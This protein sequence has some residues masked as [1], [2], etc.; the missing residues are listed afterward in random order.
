P[1]IHPSIQFLLLIW[2]WVAEAAGEAG[3][4]RRPSPQ[5]RFPALPEGSRGVPRP[6]DIYN[7][8][9]E[10]VRQRNLTVLWFSHETS[11]H[12]ELFQMIL[13]FGFAKNT[14]STYYFQSFINIH[15][16]VT[17]SAFLQFY[18]GEAVTANSSSPLFMLTSLERL[19]HHQNQNLLTPVAERPFLLQ[20]HCLACQC[21]AREPEMMFFIHIRPCGLVCSPCCTAA[22]IHNRIVHS[23]AR[24]CAP[25]LGSLKSLKITT[26]SDGRYS[27]KYKTLLN[28]IHKECT[29]I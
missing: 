12:Q 16:T 9:N 23:K 24:R 10:L 20:V 3:C 17:T 4:S 25:V 29:C 18:A 21:H 26:T 19:L 13:S 22:T 27:F 5:Q 6:G 15:D 7:P 1:S 2:S 8:S 28:I 14:H 11:P